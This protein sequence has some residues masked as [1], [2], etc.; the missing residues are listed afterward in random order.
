MQIM[1]AAALTLIPV[2]IASFWFVFRSPKVTVSNYSENQRII[3]CSTSDDTLLVV[4]LVY[5]LVLALVCTYFAYRA[6]TLPENFN[7]AKFIGFAMFSFCVFW[8]GFLPA[9]YS[10]T[11]SNRTFVNCLAVLGSAYGVLCIMYFPKVRIIV[12][13]PNQNTTEVFR[14]NATT[15]N[16]KSRAN[17][18]SGL[19]L[20]LTPT[21]SPLENHRNITP[22]VIPIKLSPMLDNRR[23]SAVSVGS[24]TMFAS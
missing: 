21:A 2:I 7:E 11:G 22:S 5:I 12:L 10:S 15:M 23:L 20:R 14:I 24:A 3:S 4:V 17:S 16:V 9:F 19:P 13:H 1:T 8:T 18:Q 6:R